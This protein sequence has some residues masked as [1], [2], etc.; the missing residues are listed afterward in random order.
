MTDKER[1]RVDVNEYSFVAY[2]GCRE[3]I[4]VAALGGNGDG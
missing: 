1:F 3:R 2:E 4:A